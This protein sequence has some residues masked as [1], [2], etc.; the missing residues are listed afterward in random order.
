MQERAF[1]F[2]PALEC[3]HRKGSADLHSFPGVTC[4]SQTI[5]D[6]FLG[7][8]GSSLV[9]CSLVQGWEGILGWLVFLSKHVAGSLQTYNGPG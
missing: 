1:A 2:W 7:R 4:P 9:L 3:Q 8:E 5:L 6:A